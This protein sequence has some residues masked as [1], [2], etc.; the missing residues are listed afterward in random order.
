MHPKEGTFKKGPR[1]MKDRC[2]K[3]QWESIPGNGNLKF[4]KWELI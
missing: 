3:N 2:E 1:G 4:P